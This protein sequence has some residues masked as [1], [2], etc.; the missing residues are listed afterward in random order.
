MYTRILYAHLS[1]S[2]DILYPRKITQVI[3]VP[4]TVSCSHEKP[5]IELNWNISKSD[6]W[7]PYC[8]L[9]SGV[10]NCDIVEWILCLGRLYCSAPT[11]QICPYH[12]WVHILSYFPCLVITIIMCHYIMVHIW[13]TIMHQL[14]WTHSDKAYFLIQIVLW[15]VSVAWFTLWVPF[16]RSSPADSK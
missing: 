15:L 3:R 10:V 1:L 6:L 8:L 11:I 14:P 12:F 4:Y 16:W 2:W 7:I 5:F 13:C 9:C